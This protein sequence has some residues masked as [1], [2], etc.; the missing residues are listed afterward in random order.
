VVWLLCRVVGSGGGQ[1]VDSAVFESV[2][3]SFE[4]EYLGVVHDAVDHRCGDDLVAEDVAPPGE[5]QVRRQD[6]RGVFVA[7]G[8]QLEKQ[9]R[10]VLFEGDVADF[11]D[12][13]RCRHKSTY[14]DPATMPTLRRCGRGIVC[15]GGDLGDCAADWAGILE[16]F[17]EGQQFISGA[18]AAG[19]G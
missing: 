16:A 4:G 10:G 17:E 14:P 2:A 6:Q 15:A 9:V 12:L 5:G 11:I 19:F 13:C 8:D 3:G 1:C 18:V 7:A